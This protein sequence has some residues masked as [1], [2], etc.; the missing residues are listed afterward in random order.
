MKSN[1]EKR[2][3]FIV[4]LY[5]RISNWF[6]RFLESNSAYAKFLLKYGICNK[7]IKNFPTPNFIYFFKNTIIKCYSSKKVMFNW[8][9]FKNISLITPYFCLNFVLISEMY[10]I[11]SH[12]IVPWQ[13]NI[14]YFEYRSYVAEKQSNIMGIAMMGSVMFL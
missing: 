9:V 2:V 5:S 3:A 14:R 1:S 13:L 6:V 10:F 11:S 7:T 8:K 4:A 12:N